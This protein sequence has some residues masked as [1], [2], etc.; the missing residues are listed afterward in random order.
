VSGESFTYLG[1]QYRLRIVAG[2]APA[3]LALRSGWLVVNVP[4]GLAHVHRPRYIRAALIDWYRRRAAER[5]PALLASWARKAGVSA[6]Q[7]LIRDQQKRWASCHPDGLVRVNWRVVQA[8]PR[9]IDYVLA[10]EVVHLL[11]DHHG[12]EFWRTLGRIMPDYEERRRELRNVG[13]RFQW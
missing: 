11:H 4:D 7:L 13:A 2:A 10:H 5:L 8:G 12:A 3:P 6:P 9:L 1:R